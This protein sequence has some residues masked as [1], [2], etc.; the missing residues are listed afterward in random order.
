MLQSISYQQLCS[1]DYSTIRK[2][3]IEDY[4]YLSLDDQTLIPYPPTTFNIHRPAGFQFPLIHYL[5]IQ[6]SRLL[7]IY[8]Y[9]QF[10]IDIHINS[11]IYPESMTTRI[12]LR[13]SI[14][15]TN[16]DVKHMLHLIRINADDDPEL[17]YSLTQDALE[18][19]IVDNI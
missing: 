19:T 15:Y 16:E 10:I 5:G 17:S 1:E 11:T 12:Q 4:N 3:L 7:D 9:F 2:Q 13:S 18:I 6:L 14:P 8:D